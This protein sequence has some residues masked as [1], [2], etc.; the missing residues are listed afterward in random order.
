IG[1]IYEEEMAK[2]PL[3]TASVALFP[4]NQEIHQTF[5]KARRKILPILP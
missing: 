2:A 3:S 1:I 5:V 4:T